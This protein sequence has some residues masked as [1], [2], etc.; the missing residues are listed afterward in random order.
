MDLILHNSYAFD[1]SE[2][3]FFRPDSVR[4]TQPDANR[5]PRNDGV[6]RS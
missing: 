2:G 5:S 3:N 1:K 4:G 6:R